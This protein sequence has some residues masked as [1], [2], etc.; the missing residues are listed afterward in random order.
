MYMHYVYIY[1]FLPGLPYALNQAGLPLGLL[2]L[3]VVAFITGE[4]IEGVI[5]KMQTCVYEMNKLIKLIT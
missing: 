4:Y 2:L 1:I 3:I 5:M